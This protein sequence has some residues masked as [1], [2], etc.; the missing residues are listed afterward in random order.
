MSEVV[1]APGYWS[2]HQEKKLNQ[3]LDSMNIVDRTLSKVGDPEE[4]KSL[5]TRVI[6]ET[7]PAAIGAR[8]G[9]DY[10]AALGP[11]GRIGGIALGGATGA[12]IGKDLDE[13]LGNVRPDEQGLIHDLVT[14]AGGSVSG[15][16]PKP[17]SYE[18]KLVSNVFEGR[19]IQPTPGMISDNRLIQA[20][21][22]RLKELPFAG[23]NIEAH[24]QKIYNEYGNMVTHLTDDATLRLVDPSDVGKAIQSGARTKIDAFKDRARVLFD[25]TKMISSEH[26]VQPTQ[27]G[28]WLNMYK[29]RFKNPDL[30]SIRDNPTINKIFNAVT[31]EGDVQPQTWGDLD[32]VRKTLGELGE[33][34]SGENVGLMK[35]AYKALVSDM[36]AAAQGMGG[37]ERRAWDKARNYYQRAI[38]ER[39]G[40]LAKIEKL[41]PEA[42]WR[43]LIS[44]K[45]S[46]T[47][48]AKAKRAVDK[49]TWKAVQERVI[50][51]MGTDLT[52]KSVEF[53]NPQ[54]FLK[55]YGRIAEDSNA[56]RAMFGDMKADLDALA[57]MARRMKTPAKFGNPSGTARAQWMD[58]IMF[59]G[60]GAGAA[61]MLDPTGASMVIGGGILLPRTLNKIWT[62]PRL[63]KWIRKNEGIDFNS[64]KQRSAYAKAGAI[65]MANEGIDDEQIRKL[66]D[67]LMGASP[68]TQPGLEGVPT[69]PTQ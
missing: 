59:A 28:E 27:F 58:R 15:K 53:F 55:N 69:V 19:R 62:S 13:W 66:R 39:S 36:D 37:H 25:A 64:P 46:L 57:M 32:A 34:G 9:G 35:Q 29:G 48:I 63:L 56:A 30:A 2:G 21:E 17:G 14:A 24:L 43:S 20:L 44:G 3:R 38:I 18:S 49:D 7:A 8:I 1:V 16:V 22:Q 6:A 45:G 47:N 67:Y 41:N 60:G 31:K 11:W 40:Q 50:R 23:G 10:G 68:N 26:P 42:L 33:F 52:D 12:L 65:L 4:I 5:A 61:Y 51:E 54:K